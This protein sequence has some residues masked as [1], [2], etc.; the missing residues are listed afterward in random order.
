V[1]DHELRA[2]IAWNDPDGDFDTLPRVTM[3]EIFIHD[4]I[5]DRA[6]A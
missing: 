2:A 5:V 6:V 1:P 4:F 3:L